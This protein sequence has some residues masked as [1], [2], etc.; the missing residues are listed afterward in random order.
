M[1]LM[2]LIVKN[3]T[4]HSR[5]TPV[6]N[7]HTSRDLITGNKHTCSRYF[8][9]ISHISVNA[10]LVLTQKIMV[11]LRAARSRVIHLQLSLHRWKSGSP[12]AG[13]T[14]VPLCH[15]IGPPV[16]RGPRGHLLNFSY[17]I[18]F[19]NYGSIRLWR[20]TGL[21]HQIAPVLK[22]TGHF[23]IKGGPLI[24]GHKIGCPRLEHLLNFTLDLASKYI[25]VMGRENPQTKRFLM[26]F[27]KNV[28]NWFTG[29]LIKLVPPDVRF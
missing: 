3:G 27:L 14:I 28:V 10:P 19:Y 12:R 8:T 9:W 16:V 26:Q 20:R 25:G 1:A 17:H 4:Q 18:T 6:K 22:C 13:L 23:F 7:T 21:F 5:N 15:G 29:K 11:L 2:M 24:Q